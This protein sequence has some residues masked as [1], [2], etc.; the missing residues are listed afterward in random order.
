M[1]R[2]GMSSVG[3][4]FFYHS[5]SGLAIVLPLSSVFAASA[6]SEP[7][8]MPAAA[9]QPPSAYGQMPDM[10][11]LLDIVI[12]GLLVNRIEPVDYR[13]GHYYV[14]AEVFN[15]L[16]FPIKAPVGQEVA[17]DTIKGISVVYES[18]SQQLLVDVPTDWLPGQTISTDREHKL[19]LADN[20]FGMLFNYDIYSSQ[21]ARSSKD[22]YLSAFTEQRVLGRFGSLSNT[23]VYNHYFQTEENSTLDSGYLRYNTGWHYNDEESMRRYAVGDVVT[24]SFSWS[25]AVRLGGVQISRNFQTRPDLVTYPL[26]QFAG[27]AAVP[28]AVDLYINDFKRSSGSVNPGPFTIDTIPFINGAGE[29]TVVVTDAL[30]RQVSTNIPF[31]VSSDLLKAGLSDYSVSTG[32][33]RQNFGVKSFDYGDLAASGVVRYGVTNW[34]TVAGNAES[35]K[36]LALG[37][38]GSNLLLYRF[39]VLSGSYSMSYN[40]KNAL[41]VEDSPS[42]VSKNDRSGHQQSLSYTYTTNSYSINAQRE[43]RSQEY[44]NLS[45]YKSGFRLGRRSD[46]VTASTSIDQFGT[47]GVGYFNII[48]HSGSPVRLLNTSFSRGIWGH[49]NLYLAMNREIGGKGFS[50]Q[51]IINVPLDK[52]GSTSLSSS[53]S[54]DNQWSNRINYNRPAP[55]AGG[56]GWDLGYAK[57][58]SNNNNDYKQASLTMETQKFQARTGVYGES[59]YTYWGELSGSLVMMDSGIYA[60]RQINDAFALINTDGFANIPVHF[61]NQ[62]MGYT[63]DNGHLLI[64]NVMSYH[65]ARYEIDPLHLP[66]EIQTPSVEQ[67]HAV[68]ESG[69]LLVHFPIKKIDSVSFILTDQSG[70]PLPK[71]SSIHLADSYFSSYVGWDG[72]VY[73]EG[74]KQNNRLIVN[75]AEDDSLCLAD[76]TLVNPSG[77]QSIA[78]VI[79]IP[80]DKGKNGRDYQGE[81]ND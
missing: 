18:A 7:A 16:G 63:D 65:R 40:G 9:A 20:T 31:Y 67:Y 12:N 72:I 46:Q 68:R 43:W 76:F 1:F 64:P 45:S 56:L 30:G 49:S 61:E 14:S 60:A 10:H 53:R 26:P 35:A 8:A 3:K 41:K 5:L 80:A 19:R 24:G 48:D 15:S 81:I 39:G 57:N 37:G 58:H 62:L 2:Q 4:T 59:K 34:L 75:S 6:E 42:V 54:S 71:G 52:W 25:S 74:V 28:S 32:V 69:G 38:V 66:A 36:E 78:P 29:A 44:G 50:A 47:L 51:F 73:I 23:G 79:C 13:A 21:T 27:Q 11:L 70:Q 33:I 22:S 55:V 77:V 17:L